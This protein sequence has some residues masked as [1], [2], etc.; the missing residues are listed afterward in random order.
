MKMTWTKEQADAINSIKGSVLVSAGAGSGKTAVLVQRVIDRITKSDNPSSLD[1]LLIVTYT[2]A[3]AKEMKERIAK[4]LDELIALQE[5][6]ITH[7]KKQKILL[8]RAMIST[9]HSFCSDLVKENF[10]NLD[11]S[12]NFRIGD[13]NELT[14]LCNEA[15][16]ETLETL[17]REFTDEFK[18]L[19]DCFTT[20]R[21]DKPLQKIIKD[22]YTFLRSHPF[23]DEWLD[24]QL[25][26]YN[27]DTSVTET[28][29][30]KYLMSYAKSIADFCTRIAESSVQIT[31]SKDTLFFTRDNPNGR[32]AK[33]LKALKTMPPLEIALYYR[34]F[35]NELNVA[36][37]KGW[38]SVYKLLKTFDKC[39]IYSNKDFNKTEEYAIFYENRA[40]FCDG[41]KELS[42]IFN[43]S[44]EDC[45]RDII[46][47][48]PAVKELFRAVKMYGEKYS[49]LKREKN[50]LDFNDL[51]H[52]SLKL[53][54]SKDDEGLHFTDI[55]HQTSR[56]FDEVM[57]DEY[58]DAN[59]VQDMIFRAVSGDEKNLFVVGDVKQSIYRFRQ[60]M[61]EIFISKSERYPV[62]DRTLEDYP[63]KIILNKNF[64]SKNAILDGVN[65]VF[66]NLMSKEMGEI[67]YGKDE[68]IHSDKLSDTDNPCIEYKLINT[69]DSEEDKDVIEA[70]EIAQY[71]RAE[72]ENGEI[73]DSNG[74]KVKPEL[75]DFCILLR[76][77]SSH[78]PTF[79]KELT[80]LGIPATADKK[81]GFFE[82]REIS[83]VMSLL[84]VIDNPI[85]DIP[86]LSVMMS[87]LYGFTPDDLARLRADVPKGSLY[88]M[89]C[90]K[91]ES[92]SMCRDLLSELSQFRS[93]AAA[94]HTDEL[95]NLIYEKKSIKAILG[96]MKNGATRI[97]N[98]NLLRENATL[99]EQNGFKGLNGF[100]RFMDKL[101]S[102]GSDLSSAEKADG[103][104]DN[105]VRI[106][107]IH[108]SK[109]LEFPI[110]IIANL[111][112]RFN[113]DAKSNML[114]HPSMGIGFMQN[115]EVR[116]CKYNTMMRK[117]VSKSIALDEKSEQL[118]VLYVAMTRAREKL[119]MFESHS[120][121]GTKIQKLYSR[122]INFDK[123]PPYIVGEASSM[124]DW[125]LSCALMHKSGKALLDKI[126]CG[127][128]LRKYIDTSNWKIEVI[129]AEDTDVDEAT[130]VNA[131]DIDYADVDN[132]L[133]IKLSTRFSAKYKWN[134]IAVM[135]VK[136]SVSSLAKGDVLEETAQSLL[137][138]RPAFLSN[139]NL[140]AAERGTALH[141]FMEYSDFVNASLDAEKE[142]KRLVEEK[143]ISQPQAD[144]VDLERV[145][146]FYASDIGK[147]IIS[148]DKLY[149]E[150]R[151][152]VLMNLSEIS[153]NHE[154][155]DCDEKAVI[156]GAVDC[157]FE[158]NGEII[159]IDYKTDNITTPKQLTDR[160]EK[161]LKLYKYAM[162]KCTD[163]RV[164]QLWLY[165]FRLD[166]AIRVV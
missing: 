6:D 163:K 44:E 22:L 136:Y 15:L 48:Y 42:Q 102:N 113:S 146:K 10:H 74:N 16:E 92:D 38:D 89:V 80:N 145:R 27:A 88:N 153:E 43:Q 158:E 120:D 54:V 129:N 97:N 86:L 143:Y 17:Y 141:A 119:V 154:F 125:I 142:L 41:I 123:I 13:E 64:R 144:A 49:M 150:Y 8:T 62:Y 59:E 85:Q 118:R 71:I 24:T 32:D 37:E 157:A 147:R 91:A 111:S 124:G 100:I 30:C 65:F 47:A 132:N 108:S 58:Q 45:K 67:D 20:S 140:T 50:I 151:F 122:L 69:G 114:I 33:K 83:L 94:M 101:I 36:L 165:S 116:G 75:G 135:P 53:L 87:P 133:L 14:I 115:T 78:A 5:G 23:P 159:I 162:E 52:M 149:R 34:N 81:N 60:A 79:A 117:A 93:F 66:G 148:S 103:I 72:M 130:E 77:Y 2:R 156:Q 39:K 112:R 126:S 131:R 121:V 82:C 19:A 55:A 35:S 70:R 105:A 99:Y 160:Y 139:T 110:C 4:K 107:S 3:A 61:P 96:A 95:I 29:Q 1:R 138:Y 28:K 12:P 109:G 7:L 128:K 164:S 21:D 11:I 90:S 161:Q 127:G 31:M 73:T 152:T 18:E 25:S 98:L 46:K 137:N 104:S 26:V 84:R 134:D 106:M 56:R 40:F 155:A 166:K 76:D 57:V 63:A 68:E 51:E 9:V